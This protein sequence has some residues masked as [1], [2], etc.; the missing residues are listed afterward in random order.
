M[1]FKNALVPMTNAGIRGFSLV[2]RFA[3][4]LFLIKFLTLREVGQFGLIS[5]LIG[6]T[7]PLIGF[8][9]TFYVNLE[10]VR[11]PLERSAAVFR[12][13][14]FVTF[15]ALSVLSAIYLVLAMTGVVRLGVNPWLLV[16]LLFLETLS[17][18]FNLC[19]ISLKRPLLANALLTLKSALWVIPFLALAL[20]DK[21]FQSLDVLLYL[22]LGFNALSVVALG[23]FIRRW[24][25]DVL[26][27][28]PVDKNWLKETLQRSWLMYLSDIGLAGYSYLDRFLVASSLGLP[29]TGVY[30]FYW[31]MSNAVLLL[32]NAAVIQVSLPHLV[33]AR[34]EGIGLW[35]GLF[36]TQ[37][38]RATVGALGLS[39][40]IY[41]A[42]LMIL[43]FLSKPGLGDYP[44]LFPLMLMAFLIR[45]VADMLFYGMYS[46]GSDRGIAVSNIAGI[47]VTA[48]L[49]RTMIA[50]FGLNGV[51]VSMVLAALFILALRAWLLRRLIP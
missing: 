15:A 35:R 17:F 9:L 26:R 24:P 3:L 1:S 29:L 25:W 20:L 8:G 49:T 45:V 38:I 27:T 50:L 37:V 34:S 28:R 48:I 33:E 39:A 18:E 30:T 19:L 23:F 41:A 6:L 40:A 36:R 22:W 16:A 43:P 11:Q 21:A 12:D 10:I 42:T 32:I 5:G 7:P 4:S 44:L 47:I 13:R 51:A 46:L 2:C 14:L 31:T